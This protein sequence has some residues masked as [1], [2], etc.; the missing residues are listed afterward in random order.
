MNLLVGVAT[1]CCGMWPVYVCESRDHVKC[2]AHS[3]VAITKSGVA[4]AAPATPS[5]MALE[6]LREMR[7]SVMVPNGEQ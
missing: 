1:C 4:M 2:G 6:R 7:V 3:D 5:L